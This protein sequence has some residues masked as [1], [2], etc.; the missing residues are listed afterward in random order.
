LTV[1]D[2]RK[3]LQAPQD[4]CGES[5]WPIAPKGMPNPLRTPRKQRSE[6]LRDVIAAAK[7]DTKARKTRERAVQAKRLAIERVRAWAN[8]DMS[9]FLRLHMITPSQKLKDPSKPVVRYTP[10]QQHSDVPGVWFRSKDQRWV[11]QLSVCGEVLK[12]G[13]F[14]VKEHAEHACTEARKMLGMPLYKSA[15]RKPKPLPPAVRV[16]L[17]HPKQ[18]KLPL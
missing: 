5:G 3:D 14:K 17:K 15:K 9:A 18:L 8:G 2:T 10:S 11:V 13:T 1:D 16:F 7:R 12:L 4:A 6:G